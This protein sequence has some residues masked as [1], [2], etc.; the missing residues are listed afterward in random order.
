MYEQQMKY[1]MVQMQE[2]ISGL[3]TKTAPE[4]IRELS[5]EE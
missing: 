2:H 3:N 1:R 4:I 5:L